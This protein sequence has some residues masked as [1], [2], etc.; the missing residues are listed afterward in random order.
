MPEF[1]PEFN[2]DDNDDDWLSCPKP[3]PDFSSHLWLE[4]LR[5]LVVAMSLVL[6]LVGWLVGG[7]RK[8]QTLKCRAITKIISCIFADMNNAGPSL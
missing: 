3:A 5:V 7:A 1:R 8:I 4:F 6:G 2:V